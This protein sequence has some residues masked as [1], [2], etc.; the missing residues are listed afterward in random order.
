MFIEMIMDER[1]TKQSVT[2]RLDDIRKKKKSRR[3]WSHR[4]EEDLKKI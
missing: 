1:M 3:K 2:A 4:I